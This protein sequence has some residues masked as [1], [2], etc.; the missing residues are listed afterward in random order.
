MTS[1]IE[2]KNKLFNKVIVVVVVVV[3]AVAVVVVVEPNI[4]YIRG[5][6]K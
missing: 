6:A 2:Q 1:K 5:L 3:A 4:N